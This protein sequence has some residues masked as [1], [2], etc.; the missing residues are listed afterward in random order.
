MVEIDGLS[1]KTTK[2][3][4]E[5]R[6][7]FLY[8]VK[9]CIV[10]RFTNEEVAKDVVGVVNKI[11]VFQPTER[12][13]RFIPEGRRRKKINRKKIRRKRELLLE[14]EIEKGKLQRIKDFHAKS[15]EKRIQIEMKSHFLDRRLD[16]Q[17]ALDS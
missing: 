11:C 6:S 10:K 4:D 3:Y 12:K 15:R 7:V 17:I 8:N 16:R 1:H 5:N 9:G 14:E 2:K 13:V